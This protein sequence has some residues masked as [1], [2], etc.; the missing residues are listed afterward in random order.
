VVDVGLRGAGSRGCVAAAAGAI[1]VL[2]VLWAGVACADVADFIG[3]PV[4]SVRLTVE[5]RPTTDP[6]LI[7]V[8]QTQVGQPLSMAQVRETIT[9]LFGLGRFDDVR[10]DASIA[11]GGVAL[12]YALSPIHPVT[13]VRFEGPDAPGVDRDTLKRAISDRYGA[14]PPLARV[15]DMAR[16]VEAVFADRGY[17]HAS[18]VPRSEVT[19]APERATLVFALEPGSRTTIGAVEIVGTPTVPREQL[20]KELGVE[21]GEPYERD[22]LA[23]RIEQYLAGRR[24]RGYYEARVTPAVRLEDDDRLAALTLTVDPGPHVRVVFAG[25]DL[26]RER[27]DE[28]VPIEREGS[29]DEDL[30]EDSTHRIEEYFRGEGYRDASAP[31]SRAPSGADLV[32]TFTIRKGPLY[33]IGSY[34]ISGN[35]SVSEADLATVLRLKPGQPFVDSRLDTEVSTIEAFYHRTGYANAR[36]QPTVRPGDPVDGAIPVAITVEILEGSRTMVDTITF[37]GNTAIDNETLAAAIGLRPGGAYVPAQLAADREAIQQRYQDLGYQSATVTAPAPEFNADGTRAAVSF[38]IQ[39]GQR[40]TVDHVLI[41]G[42]VRTHTETIERELGIKAGDPF[43]LSA[44]SDSQRRLAALGLFRRARITELRHGEQASRDLLVTIEE[45]PPTTIGYGAGVEGSRSV[46]GSD[47]TGAAKERL[48]FAPRA[49]FEISRRNLFGRNRSASL[50]TSI[51]RSV[52]YS[53]TEYRAVATFREPRL[54]DTAADAFINGTLEQQHRSSFDF[55]RRSLSAD[56]QRRFSGPYRATGTY[57]LQRT[58]VFNLKVEDAD[59]PLIDRTFQQFLLSSFSGSIIRDTRDDQVDTKDGTY[60]SASAQL[61]AEAIG[62]E[63]GFVKSSF[64]G[65]LFRILPHTNQIVFAGNA[66]LG[67]A[68]GFATIADAG[69]A[70]RGELPASERFFAGGDTTHRGFAIDQ[71]GVRH[72]TPQPGDTIDPDGFAIGGNGLALFNAE[73]RVPVTGGIGLVG[74]V[75]TGN[76]FARVLDIDPREFRTALGGGLRYRSPIGPLRID[77]GFKLNRREDEKRPAWFV[78]FGQA[79]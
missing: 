62:S 72:D 38:R 73:L 8:V 30:L 12:L 17:L 39:E 46:I 79:F 49:L 75:D 48:D 28:F 61:A 21:I 50:F 29:A 64:T 58:S 7:Q 13:A 22:R 45:A 78:S 15:G 3:K 23:T 18:V 19:H 10:V 6:E 16:I 4:A 36:A 51:S 59:L 52:R 44:I 2:A 40:V 71:L 5:D 42:N 65:Q 34:Q 53:L 57:Q 41:V 32:I 68:R 54:F 31:Y 43:S 24:R 74:F 14:T 67:A 47:E 63:V 9:H 69:G 26:P 37:S 60:L 11:G 27:R 35:A 33:R 76:V 77:L 56:V 20:L 70:V 55:S 1:F 66:R 25:D